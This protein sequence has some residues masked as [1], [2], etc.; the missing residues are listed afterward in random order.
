MLKGVVVL[1]LTVKN[2]N[3]MVF[4]FK[5]GRELPWRIEDER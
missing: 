1:T 3:E 4:N 5:D 2:H